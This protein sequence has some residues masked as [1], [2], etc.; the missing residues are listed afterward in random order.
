[1]HTVIVGGG[2]AG[3]KAAI[4]LS[5]K[6]LGK[7][8]LISNEPYFLHHATLYATAT[9]RSKDE[10]VISLKEILTPY[11]NVRVVHDEITK[12]DTTRK[13]VGSAKKSYKYDELILSL[14]VVT[15][16]FGI[17]GMAENSYGIKLLNEVN[18]FHAKVLDD[19]KLDSHKRRHYVIV[20][21][22]PSGVELA[23]A[24]REYTDWIITQRRH[25]KSKVE[26][27][28]VEAADRILPRSS[29]T[30]S[31][32]VHHRLEKMNI[33]VITSHPV[34]ALSSTHVTIAGEKVPASAVVWTSGV[35]N[36]PFFASHSDLFKLAKNGRVEVNQYLEA[37]PHVY[38][39]GDNAATPYSGLAWNALDDAVFVARHLSRKSLGLPLSS[40]RPTSPPS[41]IPV[42][43]NWAYV[44]WHGVYASG[45]SGVKLRRW[46]ELQ[47]YKALLPAK[48]A[49]A[50]WK[51][52]YIH[53]DR[54]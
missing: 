8:T 32:K 11:T 27:S 34:E 7:I 43:D 52:H 12:L 31:K 1:M 35:S 37:L 38:V 21:A 22:G 39:I 13:L 20:G 3:I 46:I 48:K 42:G 4:E 40:R 28:L 19:L 33:K 50:A 41:G 14:G 10:S 25:T 26:I 2:F 44:E 54:I 9:G 5:K 17:K 45:K 24:L 6:Q 51:A 53:E 18:D 16:Y 36:H 30:A 49:R 29:K 15:T 23:G 47:G